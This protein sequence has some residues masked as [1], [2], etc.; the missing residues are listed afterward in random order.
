[1]GGFRATEVHLNKQ[2]NEVRELMTTHAAVGLSL[3]QSPKQLIDGRVREPDGGRRRR[4]RPLQHKPFSFVPRKHHS[5]VHHC[6]GTFMS[7]LK[8][9]LSVYFHP[10]P[11][12]MSS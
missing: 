12:N 2:T 7:S 8:A 3:S 5:Q 1:M 4:Q 10:Q 9:D 6:V 11:P